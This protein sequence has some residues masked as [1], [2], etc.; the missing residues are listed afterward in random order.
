METT[1]E[2]DRQA[3]PLNKNLE[4]IYIIKV[5]RRDSPILKHTQKY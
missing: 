4:K 3:V 2:T 5:K 1:L